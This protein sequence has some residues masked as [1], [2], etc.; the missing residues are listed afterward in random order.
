MKVEFIIWEVSYFFLPKEDSIYVHCYNGV[1]SYKISY[2]ALAL[3]YP[4]SLGENF[5]IQFSYFLRTKEY[6]CN[7]SR[8]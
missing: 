3:K 1:T 7:W 4:C 5:L 2:L 8:Q 6:V